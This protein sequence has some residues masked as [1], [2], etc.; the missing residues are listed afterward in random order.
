M[1]CTKPTWYRATS[2]GLPD[3][4]TEATAR[5]EVPEPGGRPEAAIFLAGSTSAFGCTNTVAAP[6]LPSNEMRRTVNV[7]T[8][9]DVAG[10]GCGV[11]APGSGPSAKAPQSGCSPFRGS[12]VGRL[13]Q[14]NAGR[15]TEPGM[16][17]ASG[18]RQ[19]GSPANSIRNSAAECC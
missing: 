2:A 17:C 16:A 14:S 10:A 8:A 19:G 11:I 15:P 1:V 7:G 13:H 12:V 3:A 5:M 18:L 4:T 6:P 9:R